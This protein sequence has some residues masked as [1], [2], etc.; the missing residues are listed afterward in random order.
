MRVC[1]MYLDS[2]LNSKE[3]VSMFFVHP[4]Q[5]QKGNEVYKSFGCVLYSLDNGLN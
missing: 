2:G 3:N 5:E 4:R 1:F